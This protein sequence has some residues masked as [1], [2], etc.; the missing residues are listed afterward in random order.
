MSKKEKPVKTR[1]HETLIHPPIKEGKIDIQAI[2]NHPLIGKSGTDLKEILH[3][4]LVEEMGM[5]MG[6]EIEITPYGH[7]DEETKNIFK[8]E[9][10]DLLKTGE[11]PSF[12]I[13]IVNPSQLPTAERQSD[14]Q[15]DHK[16]RR[17]KLKPIRESECPK[18]DLKTGAIEATTGLFPRRRAFTFQGL[19]ADILTKR[20]K[21][22]AYLSKPKKEIQNSPEYQKNTQFKIDVTH[23]NEFCNL[24]CDYYQDIIEFTLPDQFTQ[25]KFHTSV[26][27]EVSF[28]HKNILFSL[29]MLDN[30]TRIWKKTLQDYKAKYLFEKNPKNTPEFQ[31]DFES[32]F[33]AAQIMRSFVTFN[34]IWICRIEYCIP[35]VPMEHV[36]KTLLG[37][38]STI[39]SYQINILE[40][41]NEFKEC[42]NKFKDYKIKWGE[43]RLYGLLG[44]VNYEI[45]EFDPSD[46]IQKYKE[47]WDF[48]ESIDFKRLKEICVFR[49]EYKIRDLSNVEYD[50][51]SKHIDNAKTINYFLS[52]PIINVYLHRCSENIKNQ[53]EQSIKSDLKKQL[54]NYNFE[55]K[56]ENNAPAIGNVLDSF[57]KK[58]D[59]YLVAITM[60]LMPLSNKLNKFDEKFIKQY[61]KVI[62]I[63]Y[64]LMEILLSSQKVFYILNLLIQQ[65][66]SY[67][68]YLELTTQFQ[69]K[70]IKLL[71]ISTEILSF[72]RYTRNIIYITKWSYLENKNIKTYDIV[73]ENYV[74]SQ[75]KSGNQRIRTIENFDNLDNQEM[76]EGKLG[77]HTAILL[78]ALNELSLKLYC[79][80]AITSVSFP[81]GISYLDIMAQYEASIM[82]QYE[83]NFREL[84]QGE[85]KEEKEKKA[86]AE[87]QKVKSSKKKKPNKN[88]QKQKDKNSK[89]KTSELPVDKTIKESK[90]E[91]S[92]R[93]KF[94]NNIFPNLQQWVKKEEDNNIR[95]ALEPLFEQSKDP[96]LI[97]EMNDFLASYWHQTGIN[98]SETDLFDIDAIRRLNLALAYK[99][100]ALD[101]I[102]TVEEFKTKPVVYLL[103]EDLS[104]IATIISDIKQKKEKK[105]RE[106]SADLKKLEK[107]RAEKMR[108]IVNDYFNENPEAGMS[109][110]I[111]KFS[112]RWYQR[113]PLKNQ[114]RKAQD[115]ARLNNEKQRLISLEPEICGAEELFQSI[116]STKK[117]KES[118]TLDYQETKRSTAQQYSADDPSHLET[119]DE[120]S[121][122]EQ[123]RIGIQQFEVSVMQMIEARMR[124]HEIT[125]RATDRF[126]G[127]QNYTLPNQRQ[128]RLLHL[129]VKFMALIK[130]AMEEEC[131]IFL[132]GEFVINL[133]Q[134]K[135]IVAANFLDMVTAVNSVKLKSIA[136]HYEWEYTWINSEYSSLFKFRFEE[137]NIN[138]AAF[139]NFD[140]IT[141]WASRD[142]NLNAIYLTID[143]TLCPFFVS[144]PELIADIVDT[145]LLSIPKTGWV[146]ACTSYHV[147]ETLP[148]VISENKQ[149]SARLV[150]YNPH[151]PLTEN[152]RTTFLK[153][154]QG[155][156]Q[157]PV[158]LLRVCFMLKQE[159]MKFTDFDLSMQICFDY[160]KDTFLLYFI[161]SHSA[162]N[163]AIVFD[164]FIKYV[165]DTAGKSLD[166]KMNHTDDFRTKLAEKLSK[167]MA[168]LFLI[169]DPQSY[170]LES[171]LFLY[172]C[173]VL[174]KG[175]ALLK[176][177]YL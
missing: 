100:E 11:L 168:W 69:K 72:L 3:H 26:N 134:K 131:E 62:S 110:A 148:T 44:C 28:I 56:Y 87:S 130:K 36:L 144:T 90:I 162:K 30:I 137:V 63:D 17:N 71:K 113:K 24:F 58:I 25:R 42:N 89:S 170:F 85:E 93:E 151:Q 160:S 33:I 66:L 122:N 132:T 112:K 106:I 150:N 127:R 45:K 124:A 21:V 166:H 14:H 59:Y 165:I 88:R 81:Q 159:V 78:R 109:A 77:F 92:P 67:P 120:K 138:V 167:M 35:L 172:K 114:S 115:R 140:L 6:I 129:A 20:N 64:N 121:F 86:H 10:Q 155:F 38:S 142:I 173:K 149:L 34:E 13:T 119:K 107:N 175:I 147:N 135:Q 156:I 133:L 68:K 97:A 65:L 74:A 95:T 126:N 79:N 37:S 29:S 73:H 104:K 91:A 61:D 5:G 94:K 164:K 7:C 143:D 141:D 98:R 169:N 158:R 50:E 16:R 8:K 128:Y 75:K 47:K 123:I 177:K 102:S 18:I 103:E 4:P 23:F 125:D 146:K 55:E 32:L 27:E 15:S 136:D 161:I 118:S 46:I 152:N 31:M 82:V 60:Q 174:L 40:S 19:K 145:Y 80:C 48:N 157:D 52:I 139:T 41:F 101:K 51:I 43:C 96:V 84:M 176:K 53:Y 163:Y 108:R 153:T 105:L 99:K 70:Q 57:I 171:L 49:D 39:I 22:H 12:D 76:F 9:V 54:M 116:V 111:E 2:V 1:K 83:R 117:S 154:L